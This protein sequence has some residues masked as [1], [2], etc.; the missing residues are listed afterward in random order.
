MSIAETF[1]PQKSMYIEASAGTGKTYTIQQMVARLIGEGCPLRK[2]L[3]V[4]YTEK[5]A[6]ELKD[7]I[8]KKLEEVLDNENTS[9]EKAELFDRA[10]RDVD[11]AAIFTIHSFCQKAL[12][13]FAYDAGR[14]FDLNIVDDSDVGD[15]ARAWA[16]DRWPSMP[17][18]QILLKGAVR[19]SRLEEYL[20]DCLVKAVHLYKGKDGQ[21]N[22]LVQLD[23]VECPVLGSTEI[24]LEL[25]QEMMEAKGFEA[26]LAI[27]EVSYHYNVLK[28]HENESFDAVQ[29]QSKKNVLK[30]DRS[31][32]DFLE[33]L[34]NWDCHGKAKLFGSPQFGNKLEH[35]DSE[36]AF[37][38]LQF[39]FDIVDE[40]AG[41][42][43]GTIPN[44]IV[45]A[46]VQGFIYSQVPALY[47]EWQKYKE[48]HKLQSYDDM[49]LSVHKAVTQETESPLCNRLKSL[50][51]FAIIDEFQD[52]NLLQW[53]I[54]K[55]LFLADKNHSI[56][57][58][59]DPKQS[60]YSFQG[61]DVNVYQSAIGE[62]GNGDT[63]NYN[64]RS[65][66][67]IIEGCNKLFSGVDFFRGKIPF[68][69]SFTPEKEKPAALLFNPIT[70]KWE[71]CPAFWI[72][73][74]IIYPDAFAQT[75][76]EK[77]IDC[78]SFENCNGE[79][80]TRLQIFNKDACGE[81]DMYR[82]V[83]FRDFAVL[84]R[85]RTEMDYIEDAMRKTGVP[86]IRYKDDNLY[87][88]R[89]CAEWISL[90][91]AINVPDFS[92]QNRRIL[93]EV[94][95]TDFFAYDMRDVESEFFDDPFCPPRQMLAQWKI[96]AGKRRFAELQECIYRESKVENRLM[97]LSKL[98]NLTKLRQIGNYAINYLYNHS[99]T[100]DDLILHLQKLANHSEDAD[101]Q[102]GKLVAKGS[103]FDAVQV[104]TIHA[105]KGLEFPV[106]ISVAGFKQPRGSDS[107]PFLYHDGDS[108][109]LGF[110]KKAKE[111]RSLE[112]KEEW[113]RLFYV[114]FTR[115]SSVLMMPQ[116]RPWY[117]FLGKNLKEVFVALGS[118][119]N[120]FIK[121]AEFGE[122][123]P[124]VPV[125]SWDFERERYLKKT[126]L[127]DVLQPA[128]RIFEKNL[129]V[130]L[131]DTWDRQQLRIQDLQ[132]S[133]ES[134]GIRQH[135]YST[136]AG[137]IESNVSTDDVAIIDK[138]GAAEKSVTVDSAGS[139]HL[140]ETLINYPRGAKLGNAI[141]SIFEHI[142]F[143]EFGR[144]YPSFDAC[145]VSSE[146]ISFVE[147]EFKKQS[148]PIWN[149]SEEWTRLTL[150]YVWN[151]LNGVFPE[152]HGGHF[153]E[154]CFKLTEILP[155]H[156]KA[157]A[158]FNL[159]ATLAENGEASEFL[160]S[161]CKGFIDL[162]FMRTDSSGNLRYSILDWKSDII[163]NGDYSAS[164]VKAKVDEDY[165]V[166][167]VLYSF[168]M[169]KWLRQFYSDLTETEIFDRYFGGMY[170]VFV[171]G[172][173]ASTQRGIYAHTWE[174][175]EQLK[176]SYE[177]VR[178][179]M[180]KH[181]VNG[182][183]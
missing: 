112:E 41:F 109:R 32:E 20:C 133:V 68:N 173:E 182:D 82:N 55:K 130:D 85:T 43:S 62:I 10:L 56:F 120:A 102:D 146:L 46:H 180:Y 172:C 118:A 64:Y 52:T 164:S 75:C 26:L 96:L 117:D 67:R 88:G 157:E 51:R 40:T 92:A 144:N 12:K 70:K 151:T 166:Q 125:V 37:A 153:T 107:G 100:L 165:S 169:I 103:D 23:S 9:A 44:F 42:L 11:N 143:F 122:Y 183:A 58:V 114:D 73:S 72:S 141:H 101:D 24:D 154:K 163:H 105:S 22:E 28:I 156:S 110:G 119:T 175:Y 159:N 87:Y 135:S 18:Y 19:T 160:Q 39:F 17:Q 99:C 150:K 134:L 53:D 152:I 90:F 84:A 91:K 104:M 33:T 76:I 50:Y 25:A 30:K 80:K 83:S 21:G 48:N 38:S 57:V 129:I 86:F 138:E 178:K 45:D 127:E 161:V 5:A 147:Q 177:N 149:H 8:R 93:N 158:Q 3:I 106:V 98:Q 13:E 181:K 111:A 54:F 34:E 124:L 1:D 78:C 108:V 81:D 168:C 7:R 49:I 69:K 142:K 131:T 4:T 171:R 94:L 115:A 61:A 74:E 121:N 170:Y 167:R 123:R 176:L 140:E 36:E 2:I 145:L 27:P 179:L 77:L 59:G 15:M 128:Q 95:I 136:L 162:M 63:L 66:R 97:D 155:Y 137:K 116:Y 6:G 139:A 16:R 31:I 89:E 35:A 126:I 132:K 60:I 174:N 29:C 79:L 148:L 14:P 65:T 113:S 71:E 47:T